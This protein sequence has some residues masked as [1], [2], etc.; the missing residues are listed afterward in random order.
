MRLPCLLR[1]LL[2][3][4]GCLCPVIPFIPAVM[5]MVHICQGD[6]GK[7][8]PEQ[9]EIFFLL[10]PGQLPGDVILVI[11]VLIRRQ[12]QYFL[13]MIIQEGT[14]QILR[15]PG[16]MGIQAPVGIMQE[17][18]ESR[19]PFRTVLAQSRSEP[20]R[21]PVQLLIMLPQELIPFP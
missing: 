16:I 7:E 19:I 13:Q 5:D 10:F 18:I 8:L 20:A 12:R 2:I 15:M 14:R 21:V 3:E 4:I 9:G 11:T 17:I 6:T 1:Q